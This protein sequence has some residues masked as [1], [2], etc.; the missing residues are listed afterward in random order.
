MR[1][2][3]LTA[4]SCWRHR[5]AQAR[6]TYS[7]CLAPGHLPGRGWVRRIV[8]EGCGRLETELEILHNGVDAWNEWRTANPSIRPSLAD[9]DLS[10][11]DLSRANLSETDLTGA[12][13]DAVNLSRANLKMCDLIGA[14]LAGADLAGADLYKADMREVFGVDANLEGA[15]LVECRLAEADLRGANLR[16]SDLTQADLSGANLVGADLS[17]ADLSGTD[18]RGADISQANVAGTRV[19]G[20]QYGS[21]M[22]MSG[23]Y[24][25]VRGLESCYGSALFT[26]DA[27]DQDYL[28][29]MRRSLEETPSPFKRKLKLLAFSAWSIIDFGRSLAKPALYALTIAMLFGLLYALDRGYE[30]G[31]IDYGGSA[32]SSLSPFYYS[33]V[34]YSTL[35]FGDITPMNWV[36]ELIVISEVVLGYTTLGLLL[37]I[38]ANRVAR[39]S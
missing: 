21:F 33:I 12:D 5:S 11:R 36:G 1:T 14:D 26:R 15:Y 23:H 30:W 3:Y 31:M 29:S 9:A 10:G 16:S 7:Y 20:L 35:G 25:A 28:D 27:K 39:Q 4:T 38:L 24:F 32:D 8:I 34:T 2:R 18:I 37:S 22:T 19:Y 17:D 6:P 13:L